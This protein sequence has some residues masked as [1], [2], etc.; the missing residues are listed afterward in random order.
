LPQALQDMVLKMQVGQATPPFGSA[1][2]GI[3]ALVLCG[4]T[5]APS[6]N[7]PSAGQLQNQMEQV[8]VNLRAQKILRDLRRDAIIE[9]R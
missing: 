9:Y 5:E 7:L 6:G 4:V 1:T 8:R 3:S 2:E